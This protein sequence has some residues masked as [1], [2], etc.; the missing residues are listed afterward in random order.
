VNAGRQGD[1]PD[2]L[3]GRSVDSTVLGGPNRY[4]D[5]TAFA[6]PA[7]GFLGNAGRNILRGLGL[8]N[9]DFSVAKDTPLPFLGETGKLE[10]RAELFNILNRPNLASPDRFVFAGQASG[11]AP[12]PTAGRI[13]STATTSRQL[14]FALKIVF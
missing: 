7:A 5:P 4:F 13:N 6:V 8:A 10:F 9:L 12:L 3:P 2:L 14:Q 1:R 11:E